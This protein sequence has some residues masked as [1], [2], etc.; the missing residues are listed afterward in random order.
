MSVSI[1]KFALE[2]EIDDWLEEHYQDYW[3]NAMFLPGFSIKTSE[4]KGGK[5]VS[6]PWSFAQGSEVFRSTGPSASSSTIIHFVSALLNTKT[7]I[8]SL[9]FLRV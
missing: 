5:L 4:G 1:E 7:S 2:A 3:P 6:E 9:L 8:S